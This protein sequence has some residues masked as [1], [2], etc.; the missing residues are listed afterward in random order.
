MGEIRREAIVN[1]ENAKAVIKILGNYMRVFASDKS[2]R[3]DK[4]KAKLHAQTTR[5]AINELVKTFD[6]PLDY[7]NKRPREILAEAKKLLANTKGTRLYL[8]RQFENA[9]NRVKK[10]HPYDNN[11]RA[12][13]L[14]KVNKKYNKMFKESLDSEKTVS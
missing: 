7:K 14:A 13:A 6:N 4:K 12:D 8:Q 10:K 2:I 9:T 1:V 3:K 11:E 5:T